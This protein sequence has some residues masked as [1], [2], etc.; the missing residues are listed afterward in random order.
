MS[1]TVVGQYRLRIFKYGAH[2]VQSE[3]NFESSFKIN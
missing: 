1:I 2:T 3:I